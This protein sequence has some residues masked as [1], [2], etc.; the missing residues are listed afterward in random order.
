METEQYKLR[1]IKL[2][3][4][5][6]CPKMSAKVE[7]VAGQ[8]DIFTLDHC[9]AEVRYIQTT[10]RTLVAK[11]QRYPWIAAKR[12]RQVF[13]QAAPSSV[14]AFKELRFACPTPVSKS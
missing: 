2:R 6:A 7:G 5:R 3:P 4:I 9:Y 10:T 13:D 1:V 12:T 11:M 8:G 14:I